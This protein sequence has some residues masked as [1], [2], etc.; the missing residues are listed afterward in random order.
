MKKYSTLKCDIISEWP[1]MAKNDS[2]PSARMY[3]QVP[4]AMARSEE[5]FRCGRR[6]AF[7]QF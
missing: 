1:L 2:G 3:H 4:I 7:F 5:A 6:I